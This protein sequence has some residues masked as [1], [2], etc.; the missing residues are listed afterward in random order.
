[1]DGSFSLYSMESGIF[2][3]QHLG[4]RACYGLGQSTVVCHRA[5]QLMWWVGENMPGSCL[6]FLCFGWCFSLGSIC[7][8]LVSWL[9]LLC[10]LNLLERVQ[11][12]QVEQAKDAEIYTYKLKEIWA[13]TEAWSHQD[14]VPLVCL[15]CSAGERGISGERRRPPQFHYSPQPQGSLPF[16]TLHSCQQAAAAS[17]IQSNASYRPCLNPALQLSPFFYYCFSKR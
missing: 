3:A 14:F 9:V 7:C 1:M 4:V 13:C 10:M 6:V 16:C 11:R 12:P 5:S 17:Q 8:L 15:V 2:S